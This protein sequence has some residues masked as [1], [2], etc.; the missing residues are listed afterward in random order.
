[1]TTGTTGR[2]LENRLGLTISHKVCSGPLGG[3][4]EIGGMV[5]KGQIGAMFF[6]KDPLSIQ[7][8]YADIEAL[9]RLC[10]VYQIPY[11]TNASSARSLL[12]GIETFGMH[13]L[14]KALDEDSAIEA[15]RAGQKQVLAN[16][17]SSSSSKTLIPK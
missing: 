4:Q 16:I 1:V 8:H 13:R 2:S 7:A 9:V 3:D 17:S 5:S 11:A 6:F 12:F 10:D 14:L 15:Y